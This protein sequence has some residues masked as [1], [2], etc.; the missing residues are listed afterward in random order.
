MVGD[1]YE[2]R[3]ILINAQDNRLKRVSKTDPSYTTL[4]YPVILWNGKK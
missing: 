2:N 3:D 1:P 4:Q